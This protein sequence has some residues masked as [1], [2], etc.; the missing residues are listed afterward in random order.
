MYLLPPASDIT[1]PLV[2]ESQAE[3][4]ALRL[5]AFRGRACRGVAG[6]DASREVAK[7][8]EVGGVSAGEGGRGRGRGR[9]GCLL[10]L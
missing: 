9:R 1:T 7:G 8:M 6:G 4:S 2:S 3:G 10:S 5:E